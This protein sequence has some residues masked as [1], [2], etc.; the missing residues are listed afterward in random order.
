MTTFLAVV[1]AYLIGFRWGKRV[2]I[3]YAMSRM[4]GIINE[5]QQI[6]AFFKSKKQQ[7]NEDNL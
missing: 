1:L 3:A 6:E 2:G 5:M 4:E 7:W